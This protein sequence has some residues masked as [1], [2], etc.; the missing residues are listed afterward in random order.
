MLVNTITCHFSV[1][2][3]PEP[4]P[5]DHSTTLGARPASG[6]GALRPLRKSWK[7]VVMSIIQYQII[8]NILS[9]DIMYHNIQVKVYGA[10]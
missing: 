5:Q 9:Y 4:V 2:L 10:I 6:S 3:P 1:K 8:Y 7:R